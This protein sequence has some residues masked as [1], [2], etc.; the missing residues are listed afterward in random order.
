M[1]EALITS[2][3][4]LKILLKFFLN[5][6]NKA[7]LR[8]LEN[9]FEES[10]NGIRKE[11]NRLEEA[12][13]LSSELDGNKK[14]YTVNTQHP[15]YNE[16]NQ[17]VRKHV[18][19]DVLVEKV[20]SKLGGLESVFLLGKLADGIDCDE[21][22]IAVI[23]DVIE[24]ELTKLIKTAQHL[25]NKTISYTVYASIYDAQPILK[26]EANLLLWHKE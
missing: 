24:T 3:T 4:R 20:T 17:L 7:Y 22:E 16:I 13:M 14:F 1:I 12:K 25:L 26:S 11:L 9:E 10:T 21:V 8:S 2:K 15:L 23:G 18:G 19:L 6:G 5:P